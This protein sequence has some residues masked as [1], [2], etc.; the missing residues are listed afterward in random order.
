MNAGK[1]FPPHVFAAIVDLWA[2]ILVRDYFQRHG[3]PIDTTT[4]P[5]HNGLTPNTGGGHATTG[6]RK[7]TRG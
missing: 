7:R 2:T 1:Q 5:L 4:E 3:A 6:E